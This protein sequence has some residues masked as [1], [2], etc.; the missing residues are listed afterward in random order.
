M[1]ELDL[2]WMSLV[3]FM[4]TAFALVLLF[5]PRGSEEYMRWWSLLGTAVTLVLSL[6]VFIDYSK[7]LESKMDGAGRADG[8]TTLL[9]RHDE[10]AAK[11]AVGGSRESDDWISRYPWIA[12][13][14]IDYYLGIDGISLPLI[15]LT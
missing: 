1:P 4:P 12:R 3:I 11:A 10:A 14:N 5:F 9:A 15:L 2:I 8:R 7:M 13:F 6:F